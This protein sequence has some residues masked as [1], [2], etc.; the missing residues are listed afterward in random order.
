MDLLFFLLKLSLEIVK[1][2][3]KL[4]EKYFIL[5]KL[6]ML[7]TNDMKFRQLFFIWNTLHE[8]VVELLILSLI[9]TFS[10]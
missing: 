8:I 6:H 2:D 10:R 5:Y 3:L 7:P 9:L 4:I 1:V